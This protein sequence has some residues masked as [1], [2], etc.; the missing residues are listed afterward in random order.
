[1]EV[2]VVQAVARPSLYHLYVTCPTS[3]TS[4]VLA[5]QHSL[6]QSKSFEEPSY[7]GARKE[8]VKSG[9]EEIL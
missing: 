5:K 4:T 9:A 3:T 2:S 1:M 6:Y 7:A 8:A